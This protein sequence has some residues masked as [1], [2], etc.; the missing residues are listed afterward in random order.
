MLTLFYACAAA[1]V[2]VVV[3]QFL[4]GLVGVTHDGEL[5]TAHD[6]HDAHVEDGLHLFSVRSVSAGLAF[7][8]IG[9]AGATAAGLGAPLSLAVGAGLGAGATVAVAAAL[10]SFR[11]LESDGTV[12][13]E[14][15][16]G[17]PAQVYVPIPARRAGA[18]KVLMALQSR[19]VEL[20][21]VT[22]DDEA[23]PTGATVTV[24][25]SADT[26]EVARLPELLPEIP[27]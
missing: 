26:V 6:G 12:R 24:V 23:L 27:A 3:L 5:A 19:T 18:G 14:E 4:L 16:I 7:F 13:V 1:G 15:S 21:A 20:Q 8:G 25:L 9:G 11:R 2:A 22:G 10:R 17:L